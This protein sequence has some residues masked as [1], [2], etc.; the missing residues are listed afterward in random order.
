VPFF[1][2]LTRSKSLKES[3]LCGFFFGIS[4]F[5]IHFFWVTTLFRFVQWWI[6][7]GWVG[8]VL[9]Q[10]LFILA[11]VA[12]LRVVA[13]RNMIFVMLTAFLWIFIEWLRAQGPF[14]VTGGDVGYSQAQL[15]PLIQIASF[16]TVYGVSFLVV[17][18][19]AAIANLWWG[20][21]K[22]SATFLAIVLLLVT[23]CYGYGKWE[24]ENSEFRIP[25]SQ[26]K[27]ALIQP[28]I[29]QKDKMDPVLVRP[30][31]NIHE[32]MTRQAAAEK[33][34]IIIWPET[35]I[36]SY[37]LHDSFLFR[38]VKKMAVDTKA[39][40]V[41]GTP[42]YVGDKE[43][44]SIVSTSPSGEVVSRYDKQQLVPFGEYLPFRRILFP[45]LNRVGYYD[46][47]F[48]RNPHPELISA[49][50]VEIAAAICFESTFPNLIRERVKKN[51]DFILL[52]TNDAW[53]GASSAAYLHLDAGIFR[54]IENRKYFIQAG[55]TGI[56]AVIDPY[57][58]ILKKTELN[59][60]EILTF[61]VPLS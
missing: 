18:A 12:I 16:T 50:Q 54:A 27:L 28:N 6:A 14:G 10:T 52:V 31:F 19:N 59:Q 47:E 22:T 23:G 43:F 11:F 2:A 40:I 35:A 48:D 49:A 39:W 4:F 33:P 34:D 25:N 1:I 9:Y 3:L 21:K 15:L 32:R 60:R 45:I 17:L 44:N 58:R 13:R 5:G 24:M 26:I 55:N 41:F 20:S 46:N 38:R 56:S 53:F 61:E 42:H 51:S 36:F 29:D 8:L 7:L 57:G 30:I 37:V